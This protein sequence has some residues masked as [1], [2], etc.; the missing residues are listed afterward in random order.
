MQLSID[1]VVNL[2]LHKFNI[3]EDAFV[4]PPRGSH[5]GWTNKQFIKLILIHGSGPNIKIAENCGEQTVN[6]ALT[7]LITPLVG[8]LHGGNETFKNKLQHLV[9]VK[10]C[11]RCTLI[12]PYH[13]YGLDNNRSYGIANYCKVCMSE[14]NKEYY[15]TNKDS[16]HKVYIEEHR[17]EYNARNAKRRSD[18]IY[19][20]PRWADLDLIK[21]IY[22]NAE[23]AHVD[24]IIPLNGDTVCGLHVENNLQYLTAEENSK[25]GNKLLP[26]YENSN[27]T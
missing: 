14:R 5:S 10:Q 16:Y 18:K 26:E 2:I 12:L 13:E 4:R 25:K 23:G 7:K 1:D 19:A 22:E 9:Q 6:R 24:H 20:T 3:Q 15:E 8:K 11:P 17:S 27:Y 21:R